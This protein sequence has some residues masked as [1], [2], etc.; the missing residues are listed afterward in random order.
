MNRCTCHPSEAPVPCRKR[1]AF[2]ECKLVADT[3]KALIEDMR[4]W[5][6]G[7][8][9]SQP[10]IIEAIDAYEKERLDD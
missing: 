9:Q 3:E 4:A 6:S 1:Y 7:K 8:H 5:F 10:Y 2:S